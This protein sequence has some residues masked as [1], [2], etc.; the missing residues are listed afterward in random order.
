MPYNVSMSACS[1][2]LCL[3]AAY[4]TV[5]KCEVYRSYHRHHP[6]RLV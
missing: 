6:V 2:A 5:I 4:D 1:V 3:D